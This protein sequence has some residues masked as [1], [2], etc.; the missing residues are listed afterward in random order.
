MPNYGTPQSGG[1]TALAP[2]E[3]MYL[4]NAETPAAPQASIPFARAISASQD[5]AGTTFQIIFDAA[6]TAVVDIQCSN[7]DIDADYITVYTSTDTQFDAYTDIGRSAFYRA[8]LVS[9]GG[10]LTVIAQR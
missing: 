4:F 5:D 3:S 7:V 2:G 9:G 8:K 10:T 1:L 6:P